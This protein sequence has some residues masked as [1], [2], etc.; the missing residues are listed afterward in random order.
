MTQIDLEIPE[1]HVAILEDVY[2]AVE[3]LGTLKETLDPLDRKLFRNGL[4]LLLGDLKHRPS[5]TELVMT[6][7]HRAV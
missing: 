2:R 1:D 5:S 3:K 6:A 7:I 4:E